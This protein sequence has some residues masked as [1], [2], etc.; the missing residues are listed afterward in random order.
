PMCQKCERREGKALHAGALVRIF[1]C[2]YVRPVRAAEDGMHRISLVLLGMAVTIGL[3]G[4][5]SNRGE[6]VWPEPRPLPQEGLT[7]Q[8]PPPASAPAPEASHAE[9]TEVLTLPQAMALALLQN[10]ELSAFAWEVRAAEAR[11]LQAGLRPNPELG[12]EVENLAGTGTFRGGRSAETTLRLSQVIELGGKRSR[13]L[14][15]AALERDLAAWD[16]ET[17]RIEALTAVA[18]AFIEVLRAQEHIAAGEALVRLYHPFC[19]P[20]V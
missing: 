12:L 10:P 2:R 7:S 8:P 16:Y 17:K 5:L 14:R 20:A 1:P 11:T 18:Q 4:C 13:R 6:A 15:V 19:P 9:L 3:T